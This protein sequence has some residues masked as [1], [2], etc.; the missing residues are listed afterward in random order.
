M[1]RTVRN[2]VMLVVVTLAIT[3]VSMAQRLTDRVT[4]N[5]PFSFYAGDQQL[6]AGVYRFAFNEQDNTV[7]LT[8][9]ATGRKDVILA[10]P[11]DSGRYG[12]FVDE[13][14]P[15]PTVDFDVIGG[16]HVLADLRTDTAGV[17]FA[18]QKTQIAA[19]QRG[20][21]VATVASLR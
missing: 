2:F 1:E 4:A 19:A 15:S 20:R 17:K 10:L 14:F 6:P 11:G 5:V 12:N 16:N 18:E 7:R 9:T 3:A 21:S 8:N 13:G